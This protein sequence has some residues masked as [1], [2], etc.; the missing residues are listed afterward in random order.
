LAISPAE[1]EKFIGEETE[2][3]AKM[4]RAAGIS[5]E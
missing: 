5:P 3:W 2:K 4:I 1:F